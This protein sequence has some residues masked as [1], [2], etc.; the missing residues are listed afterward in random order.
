MRFKILIS[1]ILAF[2]LAS[3]AANKRAVT[4]QIPKAAVQK[5]ESEAETRPGYSETNPRLDFEIEKGRFLSLALKALDQRGYLAAQKGRFDFKN[6]SYLAIHDVDGTWNKKVVIVLFKASDNIGNSFAA[7]E[8]GSDDSPKF[9]A[10]GE[11][12]LEYNDFMREYRSFYD[13]G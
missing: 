2:T 12:I 11:S 10:C 1:V 6:P 9:L 4:H 5:A 3:C 7:F 13:K 8:I